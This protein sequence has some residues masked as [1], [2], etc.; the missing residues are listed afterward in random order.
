[1]CFIEE[2][3][4]LPPPDKQ[5]SRTGRQMYQQT[6][7]QSGARIKLHPP[8]HNRR[9]TGLSSHTPCAERDNRLIWLSGRNNLEICTWS[10]NKSVHPNTHKAYTVCTLF[11]IL[12]IYLRKQLPVYSLTFDPYPA[13]VGAQTKSPVCVTAFRQIVAYLWYLLLKSS[14]IPCFYQSCRLNTWT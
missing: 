3:Y 11:I 12:F 5:S 6:D 13:M 9:R 14:L 8:W 1:M 2:Q 7:R 4:T 10:Q